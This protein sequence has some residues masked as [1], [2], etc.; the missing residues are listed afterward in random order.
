[1]SDY[2]NEFVLVI[3]APEVSGWLCVFNSNPSAF[4]RH[5]LWMLMLFVLVV[6][7]VSCPLH[8]GPKSCVDCNKACWVESATW[9]AWPERRQCDKVVLAISASV[10]A[11]RIF[12]YFCFP[13]P[14]PS[15]LFPWL[16]W[17]AVV[18]LMVVFMERQFYCLLVIFLFEKHACWFL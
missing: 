1:M 12:F 6:D 7:V 4:W 8:L 17:V 14:S 11:C 5:F 16:R 2:K 9:L 10:T 18:W 13:A 3:S 15:S